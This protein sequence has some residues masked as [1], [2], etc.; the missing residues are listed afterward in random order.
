MRIRLHLK[1]VSSW[2][3]SDM[4]IEK[5]GERDTCAT[6]DAPFDLSGMDEKTAMHHIALYYF[7]GVALQMGEADG[8]LIF[9]TRVGGVPSICYYTDFSKNSITRIMVAG[10]DI[11]G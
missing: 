5:R 4:S 6:I 2:A 11:A 1:I 7:G 10:Y 9:C 8:N 3:M